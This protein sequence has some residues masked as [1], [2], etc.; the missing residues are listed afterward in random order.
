[1]LMHFSLA[2]SRHEIIDYFAREAA[3]ATN[4][5][6][7]VV[8]WLDGG[9]VEVATIRDK[10]DTAPKRRPSDVERD[11][12]LQRPPATVSGGAGGSVEAGHAVA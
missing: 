2:K 12:A 8:L 6:A 10:G 7:N 1:M 5:L 4:G 11:S 3:T 9:V